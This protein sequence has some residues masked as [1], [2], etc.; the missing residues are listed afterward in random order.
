L[1][2]GKKDG[3]VPAKEDLK[4]YLPKWPVCPQG[5]TYTINAV[6][7]PPECSISGHALP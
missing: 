2:K 3:D 5:G 6:G 7:K 4:P 1:E